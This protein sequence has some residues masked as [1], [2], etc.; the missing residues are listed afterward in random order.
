[1]M[2]E[3]QP[4]PAVRGV[5][6][7]AVGTLIVPQPA[8]GEAYR[9]AAAELGVTLPVETIRA[10]FR[11]TLAALAADDHARH[12]YRTSEELERQ[13]WQAIV[14][15][16]LPEVAEQD[17][18]FARLWDHFADPRCWR[19][20]DDV[21]RVLRELAAAGV[22]LG[23]ASNFDARLE[24]IVA[25]HP[26]LAAIERLF[27][28]SRIGYRKPAREF[29]AHIEQSLGLAPAELLLVGDDPV[30]DIAAAQAAGWRTVHVGDEGSGVGDQG[31]GRN[32]LSSL[33]GMI[34]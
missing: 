34:S 32:S 6:L 11:A 2:S 7:D 26:S 24:A 30:N 19:L 25:A 28:S 5:L 18:L 31:T 22:M 3:P 20:L 15:R 4:R 17:P 10:R 16:V 13:R 8:V 21:P 12:D 23:I 14:R 9:L 33:L 27:V 29:F 1:M